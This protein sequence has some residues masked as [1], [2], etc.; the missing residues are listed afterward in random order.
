MVK[1]V[2]DLMQ[3]VKKKNS[4]DLGMYTYSHSVNYL[5]L[6]INN[7]TDPKHH[8]RDTL[9][10]LRNSLFVWKQ[11]T[12]TAV[13]K[14]LHNHKRLQCMKEE[15]EILKEWFQHCIKSI[16]K[17]FVHALDEVLLVKLEI[18][19]QKYF[20]R[21]QTIVKKL[22]DKRKHQ[23]ACLPA[24][25]FLNQIN[26]DIVSFDRYFEEFVKYY[27]TECKL[28]PFICVFPVANLMPAGISGMK[29][30]SL[31]AEVQFMTAFDPA[32]NTV[33]LVVVKIEPH[34]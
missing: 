2:V 31:K 33:F 29:E 11:N 24:V 25:V 5:T 10:K 3:G 9:Q 19:E 4:L 12:L 20:H 28:R 17:V 23:D 16:N 14:T 22:V 32:E 34:I 1:K 26:K 8:F 13:G 6:V 7:F 15:Y 27:C 18:Q 30:L 21:L